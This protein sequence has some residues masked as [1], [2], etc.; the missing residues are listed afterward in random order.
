MTAILTT[1]GATHWDELQAGGALTLAFGTLVLGRGND[2]PADG[3]TVADILRPVEVTA[4]AAPVLN[5]YAA[6]N[7][8]RGPAV[9]TYELELPATTVPYVATNVGLAPAGAAS[10]ALLAVSAAVDLWTTPYEKLVV[11]I[12]LGEAAASVHWRHVR[13]EI[14]QAALRSFGARADVIFPGRNGVVLRPGE[15]REVIGQGE[16]VL[17]RARIYDDE[18]NPLAVDDIRRATQRIFEVDRATGKVTQ[19]RARDVTGDAIA[20]IDRYQARYKVR[21]GINFAARVAGRYTKGDVDLRVEYSIV[22]H[23]ESLRRYVQHVRV[24]G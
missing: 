11:W 17:F 18:G 24:A 6:D 16:P 14:T 3:D 19:Q 4:T 23:D 20:E 1:A 8:G 22:L 15:A 7:P 9:Y 21:G 2:V 10:G 5:H 13:D 12:N